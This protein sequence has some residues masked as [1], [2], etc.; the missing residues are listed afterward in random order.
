MDGEDDGERGARARH[1][2][3]RE[4]VADVV[5]AGAAP[6]GRN[7]DAHQPQFAAAPDQIARE[8]VFVVDARGDGRDFRVRKRLDARAEVPLCGR[9]LEEHGRIR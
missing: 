8:L 7:G 2:F 3:E 4:D 6:G 5:L 9:W 1:R